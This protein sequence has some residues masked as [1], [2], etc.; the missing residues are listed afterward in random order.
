[1]DMIFD[2]LKY[3]QKLVQNGIK[4]FVSRDVT[5]LAQYFRSLGLAEDEIVEHVFAFCEKHISGFNKILY[6]EKIYS[7]VS[8]SKKSG[9]RISQPVP[10]TTKEIQKIRELQNYRHEKIIFT[11]LVMAKHYRLTNTSANI[12]H[13][14]YFLH[15]KFNTIYRLA[16]TSRRKD[17]NIPYILYKG[18]YIIDT[19]KRNVYHICFTDTNDDS[20]VYLTVEDMDNIPAWYKPACVE[21]GREFEK[22][23][24]RRKLCDDCVAKKSEVKQSYC[25]VCGKEIEKKSNRQ[26]MCDDCWLDTKMQ[27]CV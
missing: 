10:I 22:T 5:I 11:L 4:S 3:A 13:D 8:R 27:K 12:K 25:E 17:E 19:N 23:S 21:C 18:G 2:E 1:M 15:I 20:D 16:H 7:I 26:T 6:E 9:L 24:S 14:Q